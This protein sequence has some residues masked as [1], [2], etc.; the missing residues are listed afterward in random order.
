MG[1]GILE[2]GESFLTGIMLSAKIR[3]LKKV[4]YTYIFQKQSKNGLVIK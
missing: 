3:N 2:K 1:T 4:Q